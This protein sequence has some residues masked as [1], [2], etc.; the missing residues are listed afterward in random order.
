VPDLAFCA[1]LGAILARGA[2]PFAIVI[3]VA[4]VLWSPLLALHD[5]R[6]LVRRGALVDRVASEVTE[7]VPTGSRAIVVAASD[8]FVFLYP[9]GVLAITAPGAVTCWSVLSAAHARHRLTRA[10]E[11]ELVLE[12]IEQPLLDG[13]FDALFRSPDRPFS[14]GDTVE[15]CGATIRV[16]AVSDGG[17]PSRLDITYQR[18]LDDPKL[19]FLAWR[20]RHLE[21]LALPAIGETIELPASTP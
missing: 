1:I 7:I 5:Q 12:P 19:A 17:L 21:R 18:R 16:V 9:R 14:V 8:P 2:K 15:Q 6:A 10:G 13:S 20:D 3:A 11:R 4:H